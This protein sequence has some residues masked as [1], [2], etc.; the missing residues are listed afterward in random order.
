MVNLEAYGSTKEEVLARLAESRARLLRVLDLEEAVLAQPVREG[1]W[2]PL[3]F[4]EHV[5]LV[6][7]STARVQA[8]FPSGSNRRLRRLAQGEALPPVPAR[9]GEVVEGRPQAPEGVRPQGLSREEVRALLERTRAFLLEEARGLDEAQPHTFFHPFF[10][11]L[12]ALGWLRAA[13]YHEAHHLELHL[14]PLL[15]R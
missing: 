10:G 6:E 13:A 11:E 7:E 1:A 4:M 9:P 15:S 5:A 2:S 3:M 8:V 12:S 14:E